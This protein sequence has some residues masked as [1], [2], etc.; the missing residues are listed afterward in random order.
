LIVWYLSLSTEALKIAAGVGAVLSKRMLIFDGFTCEMRKISLRSRVCCSLFFFLPWPHSYLFSSFDL[1]G[2]IVLCVGT[3]RPLFLFSQ[4]LM[5]IQHVFPISNLFH[6]QRECRLKS[7]Q[8][9]LIIWFFLFGY[10]GFLIQPLIEN[11]NFS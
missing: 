5:K 10:S 4:P 1:S 8:V 7:L 2:K 3:I 11:D 6:R 9:Y